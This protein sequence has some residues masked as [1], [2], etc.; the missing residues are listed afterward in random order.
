MIHEKLMTKIGKL[1]EYEVLSTGERIEDYT[2]MEKV[3][4]NG[5]CVIF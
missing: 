1:Q 3:F 5:I 2:G 4:K